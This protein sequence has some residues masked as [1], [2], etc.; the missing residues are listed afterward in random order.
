M[1]RFTLSLFSR[2]RVNVGDL[3]VCM[4]ISDTLAYRI[5]HALHEAK[6]RR[7]MREL[8][9]KALDLESF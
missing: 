4:A 5:G 2:P 3:H 9:L 7:K 6:E 8:P 1:R